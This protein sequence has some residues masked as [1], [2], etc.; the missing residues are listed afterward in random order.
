MLRLE[1]KRHHE[2][3]VFLRDKERVFNRTFL[4]AFG[5]ALG[6]HLFAVLIFHIH[7]FISL[8]DRILP[9]T[10]VE[11]DSNGMEDLN[12]GALAVIEQEG[13][14]K[15]Y[16]LP[17]AS[18]PKISMKMSPPPVLQ[19]EYVA[20]K[21]VLSHS[22][23]SI[24]ED[25]SYLVQSDASEQK[26]QEPI[27]VHISGKLA[28]VPLVKNGSQEIT[29]LQLDNLLPSESYLAVYE[30]QVDRKTGRI[31]W[32]TALHSDRLQTVD[33]WAERMLQQ[34]VFQADPEAFVSKGE[35]EISFYAPE[36][37]L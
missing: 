27:H 14:F 21:N 4:Y 34:M 7:P 8:G 12:S 3:T 18:D 17:R 23:S 25:W 11:I 9:P 5:I 31:F 32:Y 33:A 29:T 10:M 22:F 19:V 28:D 2:I 1:K 37:L 6:M 16:L 35:I 15:P 26:R 20:S 30:V 36:G 13:G 24:E